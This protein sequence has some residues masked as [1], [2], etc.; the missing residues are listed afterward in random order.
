MKKVVFRFVIYLVM[1]GMLACG[2]VQITDLSIK[3]VKTSAALFI[4]N[5][6]ASFYNEH[7]LKTDKMT[8][9][10]QEN[11]KIRDSFY[12]S[13]DWV[14]RKFSNLPLILKFLVLILAV[15]W[16]PLCFMV[17]VWF[18]VMIHSVNRSRKKK[19]P[20]RAR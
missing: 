1:I 17:W 16:Y 7:V 4:L 6:N 2:T 15:I 12:N 5:D 10:Y 13:S 11:Q 18:V 9:E 19:D 8:K 14:I 3:L 20:Q